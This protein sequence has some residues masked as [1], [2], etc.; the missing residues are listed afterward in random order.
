MGVRRNK[1]MNY[2]L[3]AQGNAGCLNESH[4]FYSEVALLAYVIL[5]SN[6]NVWELKKKNAQLN[7][8]FGSNINLKQLSLLVTLNIDPRREKLI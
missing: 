6:L 5:G 3:F 2:P 8:R 7:S 1:E 4:L